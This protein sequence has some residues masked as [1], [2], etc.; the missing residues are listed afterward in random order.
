MSG[1]SARHATFTIERAFAAAPARVFAA[2]ADAGFRAR[3]FVGPVKRRRADRTLDFRV[4]GRESVSGGPPGGPV[5]RYDAIYQDIVPDE[6]IVLTCEMHR[7]ETRI[8]VSLGT[9]EFKPAGSGTLLVHTEQAVFLDGRDD[10]RSREQ[11]VRELLDH[12][13]ALLGMH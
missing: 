2:Y 5:H 7:D 12:L 8:S 4:G 9:T 10:A 3:W 11:G 1:R 13:A 6:R